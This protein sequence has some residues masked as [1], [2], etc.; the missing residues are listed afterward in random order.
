M[1]MSRQITLKMYLGVV[2]LLYQ[3]HTQGATTLINMVNISLNNEL[4]LLIFS[5]IIFAKHSYIL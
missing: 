2:T 1:T 5:I 4:Y 3:H